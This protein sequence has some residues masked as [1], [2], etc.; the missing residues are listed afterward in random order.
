M[1][2]HP[3]NPGLQPKEVPL[4]AFFHKIVNVVA[5]TTPAFAG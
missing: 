3:H 4:E 5:I 2:L 1:V